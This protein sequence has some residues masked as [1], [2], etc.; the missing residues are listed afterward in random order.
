MRVG[1]KLVSTLR[2]YQV[3]DCSE[4]T[5]DYFIHQGFLYLIED[6]IEE[7]VS[8][9][10]YLKLKDPRGMFVELWMS[11]PNREICIHDLSWKRDQTEEKIWEEDL[12][13]TDYSQ[14]G[15]TYFCSPNDVQKNL[16]HLINEG[17]RV[18]DPQNCEIVLQEGWDLE[19]EMF[20]PINHEQVG[21]YIEPKLKQVTLNKRF[22]GELYPY[23]QHGL[24]WL[25]AIYHAQRSGILADEMGLG[26]TV[27]VLAFLSGLNPQGRYLIVAPTSLLKNWEREAHQFLPD[28]PVYIHNGPDRGV[29]PE[30]GMIIT[31]YALLRLDIEQLKQEVF[32]V[33]VLDEAQ[34]IKNK[35]SQT[36][37]AAY[38]LQGKFRLS[39][40]GTPIENSISELMSQYKFLGRPLM[41]RRKKHEVD[42][43]L[44]AKV[45][46]ELYLEMDEKLSGEY[47]EI[48]DELKDRPLELITALRMCIARGKIQ[49]VAEDIHE[50]AENGYK[51][52]IYSQFTTILKALRE[53]LSIPSLYLDGSTKDRD[54]LVTQFKEGQISPFLISLK[55][56][57]T[58]LN[59]QEADYV[60][61]IDPWWN[62]AVEDQAISRAHRL[63]RTKA[64]IARRYI[65]Q[66][67]IE[68]R[69][70]ELKASKRHLAEQTLSQEELLSLI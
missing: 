16:T 65:T 68:N 19:G 40:S 13:K 38:S 51:V 17:W 25:S 3:T 27:Q 15:D 31:S 21:L 24:N 2:T 8:P 23:Q 6:E 42:L 26:K 33:I 70:F 55:A 22:K 60:L 59:L 39:L 32:D 43:D 18:L 49:Q 35:A 36:A 10:P 34:A 47:Q 37:K 53:K 62:E 54:D 46:T 12:L 48:K 9:T 20:A 44:P 29:L 45:E 66:N 64:V 57:G 61:I 69:V 67:S 4:I 50:L 5:S 11:Y 7:T 14:D 30:R 28:L 1:D 52:L 63:G 58:G 56:G 41:L